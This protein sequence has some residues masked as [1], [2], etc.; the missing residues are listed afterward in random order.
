[1]NT[2]KSL[3]YAVPVALGMAFSSPASAESFTITVDDFDFSE[4]VCPDVVVVDIPFCT[5]ECGQFL[6]RE[7]KAAVAEAF[8]KAD[9]NGDGTTLAYI[10]ASASRLSPAA[11]NQALS[12]GRLALASRLAKGEGAKVVFTAAYGETR[13]RGTEAA[14]YPEDRYAR[15]FFTEASGNMVQTKDGTIKPRE[16]LEV[17]GFRAPACNSHLRNGPPVN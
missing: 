17:I 11:H 15:I 5:D 3:K 6:K 8:A 12:E 16:G 7:R 10:T 1:M 9:L 13:A 2:L 4:N 14:D